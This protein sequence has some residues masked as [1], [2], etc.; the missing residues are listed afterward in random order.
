VPTHAPGSTVAARAGLNYGVWLLHA[1]PNKSD[2]FY[3]ITGA[4]SFAAVILR[5]YWAAGRPISP[6]ATLIA[7]AGVMWCARL[8]N[9]VFQRIARDGHDRRMTLKHS[10]LLFLIP[11]TLQ[12][13]WTMSLLTPSILSMRYGGSGGGASGAVAVATPEPIG[14]ID[15]ATAAVWAF[16][17]CLEVVA[18]RQ[19]ADFA[20]AGLRET[21]GYITSGVWAHSRHPNYMGEIILWTATAVLAYRDVGHNPACPAPAAVFAAPSISFLLLNFVSGVPLL[22]ARARKLWGDRAE[23]QEYIR[24]TPVVWGNPFALMRAMLAA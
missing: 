18:D 12:A 3:D 5:E 20:N 17:F 4:L 2:R 10:P 6:R 22:E 7:S 13:V 23:F 1:A 16:G 9:F 24:S 21:L 15:Y 8:G 14:A 19:K 11:F